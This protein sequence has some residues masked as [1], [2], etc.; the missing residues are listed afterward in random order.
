MLIRGQLH[1]RANRTVEIAN[2]DE[3]AQPRF[4]T[5]N[6][7][8]SGSESHDLK[9]QHPAESRAF[10]GQSPSPGE[11]PS[12]PEPGWRWGESGAVG[13]IVA[14]SSARARSIEASDVGWERTT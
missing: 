7:A 2:R 1:L 10:S 6:P 13:G 11:S 9:R 8:V 14:M 5:P 3:R 4:L 12:Y